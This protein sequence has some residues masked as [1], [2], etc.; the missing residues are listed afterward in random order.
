MLKEFA[1]SL[2]NRHY[3]QDSA[4]IDKW[5]GLDNDTFMSLYDY[6]DDVANYFAKKNTLSGYTGTIYIP[7]EFILD[8][9]GANFKN[10]QQMAIGL[11]LLLE[12]L[13]VPYILYFSGTGFHFHI[14]SD[15]FRW[16]PCKDL[17]VKVKLALKDA[18][19]FDYADPSVTD[20]TRIIRVPN[21]KNSKSNLY[22][23]AI[24]EKWLEDKDCE[25]KILKFAKMPQKIPDIIM[26]CNPVFDVLTR[27]VKK[28]EIPNKIPEFISQG[29]SP[30]PVNY[31]CISGMLES[32]PMGKRHMVALRI[33]SWFRWL[34]PE[35]TLRLVME[36]WRQQVSSG[37]SPFGVKEM[38]SII[39]SVYD[40]H[41][42]QGCRYGCHDA[43]MD[44]YC[45]NTC[46][47]YKSKK[48]Q[49]IMDSDAMEEALI[50][51]LRA[52]SNPINFGDI[53][54][55]QD[56]PIYPGEVVILQA[57]PKSMKTM[58]LQNWVNA[59]KR[60]TYF[61][62]MEMSPRQIWS[63]FVMIENKWSEIELRDHYQQMRNGMNEKFKYLTVDYSAPYA[64]ELEKRISM[65]PIKPEIVVVDHMGL[66]KSKQ[67][68]PNMKVEEAS[69]AMMELAVKHNLIVIA[70][71]EIT[72]QAF[73]EGMNMASSKGSFRTAYNTNKLLSVTP[74]KS[75][76][77]GL[78][79]QL[80]LKCEANREREHIDINL[81]VNN[82]NI[83]EM[84]VMNGTLEV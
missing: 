5:M 42:G 4:E 25:A 26:E 24:P 75:V 56:F 50:E 11:K 81:H 74:R 82:A 54:K 64:N 2:S 83:T 18:G 53:Y 57:P 30:D 33:A 13:L 10:A 28:Q 48:G 36:N 12:D 38:E 39:N 77:S 49:T 68:D 32:V 79:E 31:P 59:F 35:K 80:H 69:Q 14:P 84:E 16:K 76:S 67:R 40:G 52:D 41:N 23:V 44:Q 62:E 17:H 55:T 60:P 71:S 43:V 7:D 61:I 22:K 63:R 45:K 9:D 58:L 78:I 65:L 34:Y 66:F 6:D 72:K 73:N 1:F 37:N 27:T 20:K 21:T 29:R 8:V 19:I 47:L 51:F 46:R 3:F 70:V 15:A